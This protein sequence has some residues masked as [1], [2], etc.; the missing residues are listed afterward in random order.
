[1][2]RSALGEQDLGPRKEEILKA[3]KVSDLIKDLDAMGVKHDD[4][5]EKEVGLCCATER[6][7]GLY[8]TFGRTTPLSEQ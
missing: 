3:L 2:L 7:M 5:F 4:C 8:P 6:V 1:M